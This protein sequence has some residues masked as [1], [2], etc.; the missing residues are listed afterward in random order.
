[1]ADIYD[2]NAYL[3]N[4]FTYQAYSQPPTPV[5]APV[6]EGGTTVITTI[7]GGGGGRATGP[8]ITFNSAWGGVDFVASNTA[9]TLE[10][11]NATTARAALGAAAAGVNTD[12][13]QL[14]GASQVD[15]SGEYKVSGTQVVGAQQPAI[16]NATGGTTVDVEARAALNQLLAELRTHGLIST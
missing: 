10:I 16:P 12:I 6:V 7:N 13:T 8:T 11:T 1:M 14:N 3:V 4:D 5:I 2:Q 15:V 9:I